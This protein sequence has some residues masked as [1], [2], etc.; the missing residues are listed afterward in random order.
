M[1]HKSIAKF[2][3]KYLQILDENGK[4]DEKLMPKISKSVIKKMYE[5]MVLASVIDDKAIK[6]QRQ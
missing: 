6:L 1:V 2:D 5:T 4:V 3:V